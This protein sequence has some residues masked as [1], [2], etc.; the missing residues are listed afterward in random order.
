MFS[1]ASKLATTARQYPYI[2]IAITMILPSRYS[3][4]LE[5]YHDKV[6]F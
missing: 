5:V 4:F 2:A 3:H 1:I 6:L